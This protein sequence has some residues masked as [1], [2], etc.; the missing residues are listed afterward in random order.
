MKKDPILQI[1]GD[2]AER[3]EKDVRFDEGTINAIVERLKWEYICA[4]HQE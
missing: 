3:G 4:I 2:A 1:K